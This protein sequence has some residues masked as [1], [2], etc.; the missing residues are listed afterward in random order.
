MCLSRLRTMQLSRVPA[1]KLLKNILFNTALSLVYA[2]AVRERTELRFVGLG[3][4]FDCR[5]AR[6]LEWYCTQ[7]RRHWHCSRR[8][9][10]AYLFHSTQG[11]VH[12]PSKHLK[13]KNYTNVSLAFGAVLY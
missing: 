7:S 13:D 4:D 1:L 9:L 10:R 6:T 8:P 5:K 3:G 11:L 2:G 12:D